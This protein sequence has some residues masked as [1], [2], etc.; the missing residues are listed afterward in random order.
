ME[1]NQIIAEERDKII[2][3]IGEPEEVPKQMY[4]DEYPMTVLNRVDRASN[5]L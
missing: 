4:N 5:H 1:L 3:E 2:D